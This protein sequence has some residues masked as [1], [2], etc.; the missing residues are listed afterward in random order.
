MSRF[1][2]SYQ[3]NTDPTVQ[4]ESELV[5]ALSNAWLVDHSPGTLLVD[6]NESELGR[7][8]Q[9]FNRWRLSPAVQVAVNPPRKR[10][11]HPI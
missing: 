6:G 7:V 9:R 10:I 5:F 3:G 2:F 1:V 8:V 4:E 11:L